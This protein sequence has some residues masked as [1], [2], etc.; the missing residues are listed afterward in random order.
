MIS[1]CPS[2][3]KLNFTSICSATCRVKARPHG[4]QFSHTTSYN[5]VVRHKTCR[6]HAKSCCATNIHT[7]TIFFI[8]LARLQRK[9]WQKYVQITSDSTKH[10][11]ETIMLQEFLLKW[12]D[13]WRFTI[14]VVQHKMSHNTHHP[15]CPHYHDTFMPH[16]HVVPSR[17]T[18]FLSVWTNL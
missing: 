16:N 9:K 5:K 12:T 3:K 7:S 13:I 14:L 17:T 15:Y 11:C 8:N 4:Q 1:L 2:P 10:L 6:G 18:K